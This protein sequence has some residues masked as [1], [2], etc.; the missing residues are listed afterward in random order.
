VYLSPQFNKS[1]NSIR[2]SPR[3]L[4]HSEDLILLK[5]TL[6]NLI[7]ECQMRNYE[8]DEKRQKIKEL[9][10]CCTKNKKKIKNL[11]KVVDEHEE[12]IIKFET[13]FTS[14]VQKNPLSPIVK[15]T[16]EFSILE[17]PLSPMHISKSLKN[18]FPSIE[19]PTSKP[20]GQNYKANFSKSKTSKRTN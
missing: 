13:Y 11:K 4:N 18:Q 3:L 14:S 7:S 8:L 19:S 15:P 10:N 9:E 16:K 1:K 6:T 2:N 5:R 20:K 17:Y 12:K